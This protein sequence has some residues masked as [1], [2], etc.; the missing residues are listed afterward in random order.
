MPEID[1]F[2]YGVVTPALAYLASCIGAATGLSATSRARAARTARER[3]VWLVVGAVAIGGTAIWVMHFIAMLG[4]TVDGMPINYDMTTTVLSALV[5]ILVVAAGLFL[6]GFK[7]D[8]LPFLLGGGM[9]AGL[10]VAAMHYMGMAAMRMTGHVHYTGWVVGVSV[11]IAVVAATAA[12]W[13]SVN[14]RGALATTGA[15]MVMGV[16]VAGMHYTGMAA[17]HVTGEPGT[18]T[19]GT[20]LFNLIG[21]LILVVVGLTLTLTF[22]VAMWPT[23]DEMREQ[24]EL[25]ERIRRAKERAARV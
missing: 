10:G 7:G 23:E 11:L 24:E 25:E 17:V 19:E 5:A 9:V 12:L 21:P 22:I 3:A 1:H 18:P 14:V 6:V 4:F 2:T 15:A 13:L 20:T 16:A 8:R